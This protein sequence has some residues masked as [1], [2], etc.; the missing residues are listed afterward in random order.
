MPR[1]EL[2]IRLVAVAAFLLASCPAAVSANPGKRTVYP[3]QERP[4]PLAATA[5]STVA[6]AKKI[7]N[8]TTDI[9]STVL[10]AMVLVSPTGTITPTDAVFLPVISKLAA[11]PPVNVPT[12]LIGKTAPATAT[13]GAPITYTL[14]ITNIGLAPAANL[15][16]TDAVPAGA[17]YVSGGTA[18]NGVVS[19]VLL[20]LPGGAATQASFV[21][22]AT[23]TIT[24]SDYRVSA[25]GGVSAFG[26]IPVV[27]VIQRPS[28]VNFTADPQTGPIPLTVTFAN[29]STGAT[30]FRWSFGDG[31]TSTLL[32]PTHTYTQAGVYTVTLNAHGPAGSAAAATVIT[33]TDEAIIGLN[34]TTDSPTVINQATTFTA[35][36]VA[37][38]PTLYTWDFGDGSQVAGNERVVTHTYPT[39]GSY[40]ALVTASNSASLV[41]ATTSISITGAADLLIGKSAPISVRAGEP[42]TYTLTV[43]NSGALTATN[44]VITD[45]LPAGANYVSGGAPAGAAVNWTIDTLAPGGSTAL[46]LI[47]TAT[48][49]ITNSDYQVSAD[50]GR[51]AAGQAAIVTLVYPSVAVDFAATPLSGT[52]P[53]TVTFANSSANAIHYL[54]DFGDTLTSTEVSP[55]HSYTQAGIYSVTLTAVGLT[56]SETLTRPNYLTVYEPVVA[57]FGAAPLTGPVPLTVT[58]ANSSTGASGYVW[59]FGDGITGATVSPTHVY[60]QAGVYTVTLNAGNGIFTNS[61]TQNS[62]ITVTMPMT[63]VWTQITP[64]MPS[65][66]V[67]G[68][69]S[70]V[71]DS[72]RARA[73]LYGGNA[74]G[75]PYEHTTWEFDG[76]GWIAVPATTQPEARYGAGLAYDPLRQVT[77]LFGGSDETDTALNQ[78]WEYTHADWLQVFPTTSPLSRTYHSLA[79]NPAS[80]AVYLFGGNQGDIHLNDLWVYQNGV[81]QEIQGS[82]TRPVSRTLAAMTYDPDKN[83]LLLFG[84]RN[85][86][87]TLLADLWSFDLETETWQELAAGGEGGPSARMAHTLTYD[88]AAGNAVLVGGV[89]GDGDSLLDDTWY[90][91]DQ[92][93]WTEVTTTTGLPESDY[94][95]AVYDGHAI[96][97]FSH[98]QVWKYE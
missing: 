7:V 40:T 98:G 77:I 63:R 37:G 83:R 11:Y 71:Y 34:V 8:L 51:A 70:M 89:S 31:I 36:V 92:P 85:A 94:H 93:G 15:V 1:F 79:A 24:N 21:V 50:E 76:A 72:V 4:V 30:S 66:P 28:E 55:A 49:T 29:T 33:A 16:I 6:P 80:G 64:M 18:A 95:Q 3:I 48:E 12:L 39:V 96:L 35:T 42:I 65:P 9:S 54:W 23:T 74:G 91:R 90:Y 68:E 44:L 73:V 20:A 84:G 56:G 41:T 32:S 27:T 67:S 5:P 59:D 87:G 47:V 25:S 57:E 62:F 78:T 58:F 82:G 14:R 10:A 52:I 26:T 53:L 43:S 2:I 19:W 61:L 60:T 46:Q 45:V 81:W 88:A 97:L 22:T 38:R 13:M 86:A 17:T 75:W 69:H